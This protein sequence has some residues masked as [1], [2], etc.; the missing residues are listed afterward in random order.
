MKIYLFSSNTSS[1]IYLEPT[2]RVLN[3][4][5]S[6]DPDTGVEAVHEEGPDGGPAGDAVLLEVGPGPADQALAILVRAYKT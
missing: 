2:L 4:L 1:I 6:E 3:R 5:D